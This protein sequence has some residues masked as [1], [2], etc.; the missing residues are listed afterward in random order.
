MRIIIDSNAS[1]QR[2]DRFLRKYRKSNGDITLRDIYSRIRKWSIK[3][4]ERKSKEDVRIKT[5]DIITRDDSIAVDHEV[6]VLVQAKSHKI[7]SFP[8]AKIRGMIIHE[9]SDYIWRNKPS[10]LVMHP[11]NKHTN[12]LTLHDIM[13]SYLNQTWQN[14]ANETFTPSFCFRLDQDTSG[15]VISAKHFGAL[16]HLNELIRTR[17]VGK[18]YLAVV[19]GQAPNYL[20]IDSPLFKW[21][22][23]NGG[24]AKTFI[25]YEKWVESLTEFHTL[26]SYKDPVIGMVSLIQVTLHTGRMHQIRAH[27]ASVGYPVVGD[28]EYGNEATN[29]KARK[30]HISRQ[31]LHSYQYTFLWLN[32]KICSQTAEIPYDFKKLFSDIEIQ[33]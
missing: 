30:S 20:K 13:M 25:N 28:L 2:L 17:Q 31:L 1:E 23:K 3:V 14:N 29:R 4:N 24:R 16:Q 18:T 15:L 10:D 11:W 33:N 5:G 21:F 12:D 19:A 8:I 9:D 27:C 7:R 22:D 26:Q 6:G 32:K